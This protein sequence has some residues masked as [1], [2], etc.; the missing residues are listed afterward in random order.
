MLLPGLPHFPR[1][2]VAAAIAVCVAPALA[3]NTSSALAGRVIGV[4]G[5]AVANAQV[6]ILHVQSGSLSTART[7]AEGRFAARGLR[8]GGPYR[9]TVSADGRSQVRDDI[10]LPL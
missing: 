2:L 6:Q 8:A 10:T 4:D 5:K 3:Q 1:T 9:V 7:D